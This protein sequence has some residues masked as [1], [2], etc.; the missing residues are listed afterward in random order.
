MDYPL[1][2]GLLLAILVAIGGVVYRR[3][4]AKGL[5]TIL[6]EEFVSAFLARHKVSAAREA[7]L[8]ERRRMARALGIPFDKLAPGH[9]DR[10]LSTHLEY[11][12][13]FSVGWN[14]LAYDAQE[15]RED[16]GLDRR[17][18]CPTTIG[19]LLEDI[20]LPRKDRSGQ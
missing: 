9:T 20:L 5:P 1:L 4:R 2:V 12:G 7:I 15:A 6:D 16:A 13:E 10:F 14:D 3:H 19:E 11:L 18:V 17:A 8:N